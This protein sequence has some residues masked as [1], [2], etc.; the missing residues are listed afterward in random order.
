M[1]LR[2]GVQRELVACGSPKLMQRKGPGSPGGASTGERK[3]RTRRDRLRPD[4]RAVEIPSGI[5]HTAHARVV[6]MSFII[7]YC[8]F[9]VHDHVESSFRDDLTAARAQA[10][11]RPR[12]RRRAPA[13]RRSDADGGG[14]RGRVC[15]FRYVDIQV[16]Y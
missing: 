6:A 7:T 13:S 1:S 9:V 3:A 4:A 12:P 8:L 16:I 14:A 15:I 10:P 5:R 2:Q 11:A